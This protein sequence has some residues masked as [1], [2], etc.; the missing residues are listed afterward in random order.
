[1]YDRVRYLAWAIPYFARGVDCDLATSGVPLFPV[2]ELGSLGKL[3]DFS[4]HHALRSAIA[5]YN[6]VSEAETCTALGAAQAIWLA[7]ASV[8]KPGDEVLV[9]EPAYEPL[10]VAARGQGLVVRRLPRRKSNG[11]AVDPDDVKS[12]MTP[13][14]RAVMVTNLHNP[15]GVAMS[16]DAI[17]ELSKITCAQGVRLIVDEVY[18]PF[19]ALTD[20]S[21]IWAKSARRLHENV[22]ALG[23]LTKCYGMAP[24]R[25]GWVLGPPS[26]IEAAHDAVLASVGHFPVAQA[27]I[28][29]NVFAELGRVAKRARSSFAGKREL[30]EAWVDRHDA[31]SWVNPGRGIFG[32]VEVTDLTDLEPR[33][34][35]AID[36]LGVFVVPGRH[37]ECPDGFRI[38]WTAE[39]DKI[40]RGLG[41]LERALQLA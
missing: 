40:E 19:D 28:G 32:L 3:T 5:R 7:Y 2:E 11:Y 17:V 26:V 16:D 14:T 30:V 9:E 35:H 31:L 24:Q 6:G 37:F 4:A 34:V 1:M 10:L 22:I 33:L 23:S 20:A 29:V 12:L 18:A 41:L 13:K 38:A 36:E 27:K 15:T 8:A 25:I 39:R 21:G